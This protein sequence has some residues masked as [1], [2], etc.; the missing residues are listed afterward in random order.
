MYCSFHDGSKLSD[1]VWVRVH[2]GPCLATVYES[3]DPFPSVAFIGN[4]FLQLKMSSMA[5]IGDRH[6]CLADGQKSLAD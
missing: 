6:S 2:W 3:V 5:P 1:M 4:R